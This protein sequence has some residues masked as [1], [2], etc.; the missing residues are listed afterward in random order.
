MDTRRLVLFSFLL[1]V[2]G[3]TRTAAQEA[4]PIPWVADQELVEELQ[5]APGAEA[6]RAEKLIALFQQA[7]LAEVKKQEVQL[8][9]RP[10][11]RPAPQLFN[12]IAVLPG[13]S[14][15]CIVVGAHTD[16][17]KGGTGVIDDWSGASLLANIA[18]T[19]GPLPRQHTF[20]FIGFTLEEARLRG[21]TH[22]V[23]HLSREEK[24]RIVAMVNLD[25]LGVSQTFL[26]QTGSAD[27]LETLASRVAAEQQAPLTARQLR[28][29]TSDSD[30]F[31]A[32]SI[33]AITFDSLTTADFDLIDS[34]RDRFDA[35]NPTN[36]S[37]QYHFLV[38]YLLALDQT[39]GPI[40]PANKDR[41]PMR[42]QPGFQPDMKKL[43]EE[44]T[45]VAVE[46]IDWSPEKQAGL[47]PG[48]IVV[49]FGGV[50]V[51]SP[52]DFVQRFLGVKAGDKVSATVNRDGKDVELE[53]QY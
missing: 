1:C 23:R 42:L 45:V 38:H 18:Q 28:N 31:M 52:D 10:E 53:I 35:I 30:A 21:S 12:V 13:K 33:P 9:G 7:G 5:A 17:T 40:D 36:Y 46:V 47:Q 16:F 44:G 3:T 19:L 15:D 48:D 27:A 50:V 20:L 37:A 22:Y 26:W 32:A 43:R 6:E 34:P 41:P 49:K 29:V 25:C 39:K 24:N 4:S 8:P 51:R 11:G 14:P 2:V